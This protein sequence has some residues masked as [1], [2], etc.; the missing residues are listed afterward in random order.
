M[1]HAQLVLALVV[2]PAVAPQHV[3][4]ATRASQR[5]LVC[6]ADDARS[7]DC[8]TPRKIGTYDFVPVT[9][10][11]ALGFYCAY[12]GRRIV[13]PTRTVVENV[14]MFVFELEPRFGRSQVLLF[15][16]GFGD[17]PHSVHGA[18]YDMG[19]V[20]EIV[21]GCLGFDP[22]T[23]TIQFLVPHGHFDH[24]NAAAPRALAALGYALGEIRYHVG[25]EALV[26]ANAWTSPSL[27]LAPH[28]RTI[29]A[30]GACGQEIGRYAS[31]LGALWIAHRP[32]HTSGS[33]DLVV[34]V[35][36]DV[37]R[38]YVVLGSTPGGACPQSPSGTV[39]RV[40]AHG[41]VLLDGD[42]ECP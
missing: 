37:A 13:T 21:R 2:L 19:L 22:A 4:A 15:G 6:R 35:H 17:D 12:S 23:T 3:P 16:M 32:G 7:N 14:G 25:D 27:D 36:G 38:R 31:P 24:V 20:D 42:G 8:S 34:D 5:A 29:T 41:N 30:S 10:D 33:I 18:A 40:L 26:L 11:G 9:D 1:I 39:Q 28:L